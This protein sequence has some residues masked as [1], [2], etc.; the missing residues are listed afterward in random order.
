MRA[1]AAH[2]GARN[3]DDDA[4]VIE[5]GG[6][7]LVLTHDTMVEGVHFLPG[8]DPADIAWKLVSTNI[9]DLAAKGAKPLGVL[10]GYQL[11][12]DDARFV[13]GLREALDHYGAALLGGDTVGGSGPQALGLTAIGTATVR[14]VPSRAGARPGHGLWLTGRLGAAMIGFEALKSGTGDS[15]AYRR[16]QARLTEGLALAPQVSAM[17]DVSDGLLLDASR[18]ARASNVTFAIDSAAV[19]LAVPEG[20]RADALRWGDDYEL[21]F[22][23]PLG[24]E[25][26][27]AAIRVGTALPT[28]D[29]AVLLDGNPLPSG[30]MGGFTHF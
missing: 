20:R 19:P 14:P 9:S 23:L 1:L 12:K 25:P 16:P 6:E 11:G 5:I 17:M 4:A 30:D 27:V 13:S 15:L 28:G 2:P 3:F 26:A 18:M 21:L 7:A 22:T 29:S 10:L 24:T 8:Q